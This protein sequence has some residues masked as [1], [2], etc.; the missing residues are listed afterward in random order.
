[1]PPN[2]PSGSRY[3]D[4]SFRMCS[5]CHPTSLPALLTFS[6]LSL[7][8]LLTP[9]SPR[10]FQNRPP[11]APFE[12]PRDSGNSNHRGTSIENGRGQVRGGQAQRVRSVV[13]PPFTLSHITPARFLAGAPAFLPGL[14]G[15]GVSNLFSNQK[16][17]IQHPKSSSTLS[18]PS[19][20]FP[21]CLSA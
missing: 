19:S 1:M 12:F 8:P 9:R 13:G 3:K 11:R 17:N 7:D 21:P 10:L 6:S 2:K 16:L 20:F 14:C 18:L 5:L 15:L 4:V